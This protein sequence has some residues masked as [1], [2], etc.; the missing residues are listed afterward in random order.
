MR[1]RTVCFKIIHNVNN[2]SAFRRPYVEPYGVAEL[3]DQAVQLCLKYLEHILRLLNM[4][5]IALSSL[6]HR[7]KEVF[8][9]IRAD[10]DRRRRNTT[11][12]G[13][14]CLRNYA[15][16]VGLADIC[17]AIGDE[18]DSIYGIAIEL[19]ANLQPGFYPAF[20]QSR[21]ISR[22]DPV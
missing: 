8:V 2:A 20:V 17:L 19:F 3:F 13:L 18:Q 10:A 11:G 16:N 22:F 14:F 15:V 21:R 1:A 12:G 7:H 4:P 9:K 6:S 5:R